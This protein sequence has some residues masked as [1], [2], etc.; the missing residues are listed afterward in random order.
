MSDRE[1]LVAR[2]KV[3][4]EFG[5]FALRCEDLDDVLT[6]ACRLVGKALGTDLAKIM[7]IEGDRQHLLVRAGAGWRP[8][9]VGEKRLPM[10]ERSSETYS[11]EARRP[12]IARDIAEEDRFEFAEFLREHG[13]VALVNVPIFLPGGKPYGLLQ[14]DSREPRD[15]AE[16]D[17]EF[18][19][20]YATIL[21]PVIDRLHKAHSLKE[22]LDA[23][24]RLL[25]E[26]QHRI[27]NHIGIITSLVRLRAG[28]ATSEEARRELEA[29]GERIETLR[30]VH[31]QLYEAGSAE[32]LRLRPFITELVE[33]L[34][35]LHEEQSGEVRLDLAIEEVD[36]A[37]EVAVPLGLILTE[38]VTNSLKYAFDGRG[39]TIAIAVDTPERGGLRVR[40]RDDGKGLPAEPRAA[41]GPGSGTGMGII[42]ALADQI[43]AEP[44]WSSPPGGGT[45]LCLETQRRS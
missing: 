32:R 23:N 27:K 42:D 36:L 12:V 9:I 20:T 10:G 45:A 1:Q 30:L 15:F 43:D 3:L 11:I 24:R 8:G 16:E 7:E 39:G 29:V 26:L 22:A 44:V 33:N 2:Q 21:G 37:P 31:E 41:A 18:L 6:E 17:T 13:A 34:C 4:A 40:M 35:H 25:Q 38:F 19:R 14:V 5:D 28:Q